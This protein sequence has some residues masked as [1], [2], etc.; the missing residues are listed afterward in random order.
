MN[1]LKEFRQQKGMS[2]EKLASLVGITRTWENLC[3]NDPKNIRMAKE[4]TIMSYAKVLGANPFEIFGFDLLNIEVKT[5]EDIKYLEYWIE[6]YKKI[7][8]K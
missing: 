3:E 1:K 6:E 2:Q 5:L 8:T 4:K 7:L